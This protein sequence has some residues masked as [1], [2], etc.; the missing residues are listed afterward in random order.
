MRCPVPAFVPLTRSPRS[1]GRAIQAPIRTGIPTSSAQHEWPPRSH[2]VGGGWGTTLSP[3]NSRIAAAHPAPRECG[4]TP[5]EYPRAR[6]FDRRCTPD[7]LI[8][9]SSGA[10]RW[11]LPQTRPPPRD[12]AAMRPGMARL[13]ESVPLDPSPL[14][15]RLHDPTPRPGLRRDRQS[16]GISLVHHGFRGE[17]SAPFGDRLHPRQRPATPSVFDGIGMLHGAPDSFVTQLSPE[18]D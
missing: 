7:L 15:C 1:S 2:R 14:G 11:W 17:R 3:R 5:P 12:R 8:G 10:P 6:G 9:Q 16:S 18:D 4:A 13:D